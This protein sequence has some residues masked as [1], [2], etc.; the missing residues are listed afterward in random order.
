MS[1]KEFIEILK[2]KDDTIRN[3]KEQLVV[4]DELSK[5]EGEI[6]T[7]LKDMVKTLIQKIGDNAVMIKAQD[8]VIVS[9]EKVYKHK[10]ATI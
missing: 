4:S 9:L 3:L 7:E 6:I 10:R 2:I 8:N 5:C 1:K